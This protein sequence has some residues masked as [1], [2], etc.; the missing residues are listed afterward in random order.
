VV[1]GREM[2]EV[3]VMREGMHGKGIKERKR[4]EMMCEG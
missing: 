1:N 4:R 3:R 2:N